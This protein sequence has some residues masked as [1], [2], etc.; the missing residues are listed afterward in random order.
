MGRRHVLG[1]M[2]YQQQSKDLIPINIVRH[3]AAVFLAG[4]VYGSF[5]LSGFDTDSF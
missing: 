1:T 4:T 2:V 3:K 5:S